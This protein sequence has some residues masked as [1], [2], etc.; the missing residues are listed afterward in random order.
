MRHDNY[1]VLSGV[2]TFARSEPW[3]S[4]VRPTGPRGG[5]GRLAAAGAGSGAGSRVA[6]FGSL[7]LPVGGPVPPDVA[8]ERWLD[9]R[10]LAGLGDLRGEFVV[11]HA[12]GRGDE[13]TIFRSLTCLRPVYYSAS[14]A[15]IAW[16]TDSREARPCTARSFEPDPVLVA[17]LASDLDLPADASWDRVVSRLPAG[18][19]LILSRTGWRAARIDDFALRT[20]LRQ[21]LRQS[22][23]QLRDAVHAAVEYVTRDHKIAVWLSGGLDSGVIAYEARAMG[24]VVLPMYAAWDLPAYHSEDLAAEALAAHIGSPL[25][26]LDGSRT[27]QPGGDYLSA[28]KSWLT[29]L[30]HGSYPFYAMT[31][32]V[33][34]RDDTSLLVTGFGADQLFVPPYGNPFRLCGL[35][36]LDPTYLGTPLWHQRIGHGPCTRPLSQRLAEAAS[37][38]WGRLPLR[39]NDLPVGPQPPG[40]WMNRELRAEALQLERTGRR[41]HFEAFLE[42]AGDVDSSRAPNDIFLSYLGAKTALNSLTFE[43]YSAGRY[44]PLG[45]RVA[46]PFLDRR[47]V[48]LCL[49][50]PVAHRHQMHRG[51]PVSKVALRWAY[52]EYLPLSTISRLEK[53][54]YGLVDE[55]FL[56]NNRDAA[57]D[58]LGPSSYLARLGVVEPGGV[59]RTLALPPWQLRREAKHLVTAMA[60]EGWLQAHTT[61]PAAAP[62]TTSAKPVASNLVRVTA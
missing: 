30:T 2:A 50:L 16:S 18:E 47:I 59:K 27:I 15:G 53:V 60:L 28:A 17:A 12:A 26:R 54:N 3:W 24:R 45:I 20:P 52:H 41:R 37:E 7:E 38:R 23:R 33:L 4:T 55:V 43:S 11:F 40:E 13:L 31:A 46:A 51:H 14:R 35:R 8:L 42:L 49:R 58:I 9:R 19:A 44:A 56:L 1:E 57:R 22:A 5:A 36:S 62:T 61:P 25:T 32:D 21:S 39:F 34:R 48:E 6:W 10:G 29:P